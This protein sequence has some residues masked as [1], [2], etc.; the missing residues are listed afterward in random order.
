MSLA[1]GGKRAATVEFEHV[2]KRYDAAA[3]GTPGAVNDLASTVPAGKI[4][5]LVGPSG[6]GKTTSLKMV[7]RLI[8]PTGGQILIDG[9]DTATRDVT[10]LR[11]GIGYVIQQV[12]LF[13]HQT[14]GENVAVVPRL[15]GWP[16]GPPPRARGGAAGA[17][18]ASIRPLP[19]PLPEPA[20]GRRA[21][22]GRRRPRAG[23]R[24][25]DHAH[26]RAVRRG[27]PDRPRAAPERVPAPPGGARQDDPVR[28]PRHRR[29]DQDGRPR[30]GH[31]GR[32]AP[33]P[34]RAAGRD[35]RRPGRRV[36]GPLRRRGPRPQAPL[37]PARR[38]LELRPAVTARV[39]DDA[40]DARRRLSGGH[41]RL[42]APGRRRRPTDRLD[43]PGPDP[44]ERPAR[45]IDGRGR[46]R[47]CSTAGRPCKDA[48][49]MLLDARRP[50]RDRRRPPPGGPRPR[51]GRPDRRVHARAGD[52][53]RRDRSAARRRRTSLG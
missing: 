53:G 24:P 36:R 15:L 46:C 28:H 3:K 25:T 45:R 40:A 42:P 49:S 33:R 43:R 48:L 13:P 9:V 12:G 18:R 37:A 19:R 8:E 5:V 4:C 26:G 22:A 50:G 34:V 27:R 20:L 10:E 29:G 35:P 32:A 31:A 1:T 51:D 44:A 2:T 39:G 47:R 23:G 6:C 16:D 7:N 38:R 21:P 17:R 11:R 52:T 30:R 41:V 14:I